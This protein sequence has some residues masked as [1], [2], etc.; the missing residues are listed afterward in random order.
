MSTDLFKT[1]VKDMNE[2]LSENRKQDGRNQKVL[3]EDLFSLEKKFRDTLISTT[4][5]KKVYNEFVRFIVEEKGNI[6]SARVYFRERQDVFSSKISPNLKDGKYYMLYR[7]NINYNFAKWVCD[8]Y[9]G[10][11]ARSLKHTYS[12]IID[13][14][15]I[16]CENNM[17]LAINRAKIFWS[18]TPNSNLEY[19]DVIQNAGEGLLTAID[20]FVPP[21]KSVFRSVAIGRMT[22]NILTDHNATTVKFSPTEKRILYRANNARVKAGLDNQSDILKYV[23]ESFKKTTPEKLQQI[24][25]AASGVT[26]LDTQVEDSEVTVKDILVSDS[27][28]PEKIL[29]LKEFKA[30]IQEQLSDLPP[31]EMKVICMKFGIFYGDEKD[32]QKKPD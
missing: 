14:R 25:M 21:Y 29:L 26:S 19:M 15:K 30:K 4:E 7:F 1:F 8:R 6:L 16:L 27:D 28:S 13:T 32:T 18:K 10:P 2:V 31:L 9:K 11:K 22:L 23:R 24:V 20:K 17:P 3:L 12:K 5:G